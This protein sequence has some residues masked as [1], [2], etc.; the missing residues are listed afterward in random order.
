MAE[1]SEQR[2]KLSSCICSAKAV[3]GI[4]TMD[5]LLEMFSVGVL[6]SVPFATAF[7]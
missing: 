1:V 2:P 3:M 5:W 6:N 4:L 7:F